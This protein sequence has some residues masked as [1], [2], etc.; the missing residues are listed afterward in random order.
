MLTKGRVILTLSAG[1]PLAFV[2]EVV[3][4][5]KERLSGINQ[6][7]ATYPSLCGPLGR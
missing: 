6:R 5:L 3:I 2:G 4:N 7:E 1:V